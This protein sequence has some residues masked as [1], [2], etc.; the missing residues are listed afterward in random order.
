MSEAEWVLAVDLGTTRTRAAYVSPDHQQPVLVETSASQSTW[1][2]S[3]VCRDPL[4]GGW[5]VGDAADELRDGWSDMY[6][7]NGKSSLGQSEPHFINGH[8]FSIL[9]LVAQPLIHIATLARAQARHVFEKLALA[10]PVEFGD[11]RHDTLQQAGEMAGFPLCCISVTTEAEAVARAA[12]GPEPEH[13]RWLIFDMGGGTLDVALY[14]TDAKGG[15]VLDTYGTAVGGNAIDTEIMNYL[16][17]EYK[18]AAKTATPSP[19]AGDEEARLR[20]ERRG[21]MRR[22]IQLRDAAERAKRSVT[23]Q[24]AGRGHISEPPVNMV[25]PPKIFRGLVESILTPAFD[26]I[27][28]M[29]KRNGELTWDKLTAVI[30]AGGSTRSPVIRELLAERATVRSAATKPEQAVVLGLLAPPA[31]PPARPRR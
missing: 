25:L 30:C 9:E 1:L 6:F 2:P 24:H 13:G 8:P 22:E 27:S 10:V 11:L 14:E 7:R 17:N 12:L 3:T 5:L 18:L 31:S 21:E 23:G 15:R 26:Q 16:Q 29:L 19:E 4:W 28:E 20:A